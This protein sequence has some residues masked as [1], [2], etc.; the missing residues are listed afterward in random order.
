MFTTAWFFRVKTVNN[1][2]IQQKET[3]QIKYGVFMISAYATAKRNR[4]YLSLIYIKQISNIK[5]QVRK[6]T[7]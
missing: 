5:Y 7:E 4:L 6:I 3:R 2:S 1:L